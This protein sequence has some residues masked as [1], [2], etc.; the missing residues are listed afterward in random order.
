MMRSVLPEHTPQ[1]FYNRVKA[2]TA[3]A[4]RSGE[5][6]DYKRLGL[7]YEVFGNF[8]YGAT[9]QGA[10]FSRLQL[11]AGSFGAHLQAHLQSGIL[12]ALR[13]SSML[14]EFKD[15]ALVSRGFTYAQNGCQ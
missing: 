10:G 4:V 14:N 3:D 15:Q 6:W 11:G 12:N 2:G 1:W 8:N 9:G 13:P 7:E 5:S